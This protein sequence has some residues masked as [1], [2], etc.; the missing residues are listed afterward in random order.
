MRKRAAAAYF[1]SRRAKGIDPWPNYGLTVTREPVVRRPAVDIAGIGGKFAHQS[2]TGL[3]SR[4]GSLKSWPRSSGWTGGW[5]WKGPG[6]P[7]DNGDR[8]CGQRDGLRSEGAA[9]VLSSHVPRGSG[10]PGAHGAIQAQIRGQVRWPAEDTFLR[11]RAGRPGGREEAAAGIAVSRRRPGGDI[12][13]CT[14]RD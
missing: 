7:V 4:T 9:R 8:A 1:S 5:A 3:A 11:R 10:A 12:M 13:A 6:H 14:V 2:S